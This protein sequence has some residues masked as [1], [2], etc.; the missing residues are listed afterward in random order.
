MVRRK[1]NSS[2][3]SWMSKKPDDFVFCHLLFNLPHLRPF[4]VG[5]LPWRWRIGSLFFFAF[6][7]FKCSPQLCKKCV[8]PNQ[9]HISGEQ[10]SCACNENKCG[11]L[12]LKREKYSSAN[13]RRQDASNCQE[14]TCR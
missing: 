8:L 11:V 1:G 10:L 6:C 12:N 4:N 2:R 3:V 9:F 7:L 14:Q 5:P 13:V